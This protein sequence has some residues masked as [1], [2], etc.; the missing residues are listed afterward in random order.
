M[1]I[2][3]PRSA[4]LTLIDVLE[5]ILFKLAENNGDNKTVP[6]ERSLPFGLKYK[7][8][9]NYNSLVTA[10]SDYDTKRKEI[11]KKYGVENEET[12]EYSIQDEESKSKALDE[13]TKMLAESVIVEVLKISTKEIEEVNDES[14]ELST[15]DIILLQEFLVKKEGN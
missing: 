10:A 7:L 6:V 3:I 2:N 4:V 8:V 11:I 12:H 1:K 14:I 9:S 5:K 15:V 13:I